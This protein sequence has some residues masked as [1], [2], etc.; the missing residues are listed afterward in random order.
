MAVALLVIYYE[1]RY[2]LPPSFESP[3]RWFGGVFLFEYRNDALGLLLLVPILYAAVT[4]GWRRALVVM[5]ALLACITPYILD[6]SHRPF[7]ILTSVS[8]I[9][10]PSVLVMSV[11]IKLIS[12]ANERLAIEEKKKE[13]TEILRQI[14]LAQEGERKRISRELHDGVA[15]SLLVTATVAHNL[16]DRGAPVDEGMRVDLETIRE[17]SLGLVAE[18]RAICQDLRPSILDNLG[19]I[20]AIKWLA[21]NFQNETGVHVE[22]ALNGRAHDLDQEES[23]SVF[24]VV[25]EALNNVKK[26]ARAVSVRVTGEFSP[27]YL[28]VAVEDD[29]DGF[30]PGEDVNRFALAGRLGLLGMI[31]RARAI[32]GRVE[33]DSTLGVGTRVVFTVERGATGSPQASRAQHLSEDASGQT[34]NAPPSSA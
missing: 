21:E 24:R 16:L 2:S 34:V 5:I 28:S 14:I 33:I 32:G 8:F 22:V 31:D 25:Q 29:G 11:E 4:L 10:I 17:N 9:I 6:L 13:R 15:Q 7:S 26:H 27:R 12:D 18:V 19:V 20:S 30:N 3:W 1:H 23:L